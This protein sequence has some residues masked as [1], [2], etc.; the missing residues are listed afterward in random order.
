MLIYI[1]GTTLLKSEIMLQMQWF[2]TTIWIELFSIIALVL[3]GEKKLNK[4]SSRFIRYVN[5]VL[6]VVILSV[7]LFKQCNRKDI[8]KE[9]QVLADWARNN[10]EIKSL[11]VLP[12]DFTHFKTWSERSSWV[13]FKAISHQIAYLFPW[14]DRINRIYKINIESRRSGRNLMDL[15][16]ANYRKLDEETLIYLFDQQLVNYV[17][18]PSQ[19]IYSDQYKIVFHTSS[20]LVLTKKS[21]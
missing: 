16:K 1:V 4:F 12:P 14:Y 11:F 13:D 7:S 9:E 15:A 20:Y 10:T 18:L 17:I 8:F 19:A 5:Y 21:F 6:L 2:K 3:Y